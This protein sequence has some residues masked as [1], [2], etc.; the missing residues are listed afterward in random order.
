MS[1]LDQMC[2]A[3][4][5]MRRFGRWAGVRYCAKKGIDIEISLAV[6]AGA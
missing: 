6:F 4:D 2:F 5:A 3:Q 1:K